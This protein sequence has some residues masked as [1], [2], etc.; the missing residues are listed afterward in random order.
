MCIRDRLEI[1][2]GFGESTVP[3]DDALR[4]LREETGIEQAELVDLG[5]VFPNSGLLA[6]Q[7][8]LFAALCTTDSHLSGPQDTDEIDEFSWVPADQ[9]L[10]WAASSEITDSYTICALYRAL[11]RG[12]ITTSR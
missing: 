11:S 5:S 4:E 12:L 1:P 9:A 8:H 2:R 6:L 3:A 10:T 7:T